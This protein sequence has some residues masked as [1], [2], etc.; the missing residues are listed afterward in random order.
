[1]LAGERLPAWLLGRQCARK[2]RIIAVQVIANLDKI[3]P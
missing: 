3:A 1:M 2:Y